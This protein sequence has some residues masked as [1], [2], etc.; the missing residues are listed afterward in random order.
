MK[1][2]TAKQIRDNPRAVVS[3][4]LPFFDEVIEAARKESR[5]LTLAEQK[6]YTRLQ[7]KMNEIL[8][9]RA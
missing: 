3:A 5:T 7:D 4:F 6:R 8:A 1:H 2:V 9:R